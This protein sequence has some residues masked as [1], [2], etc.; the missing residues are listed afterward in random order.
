MHWARDMRSRILLFIAL[1]VLAFS[2]P[3]AARRH[4][5]IASGGS[6]TA[7]YPGDVSGANWTTAWPLFAWTS[8]KANAGASAVPVVNVI[9]ETTSTSCTIYL[10]GDGTPDVDLTTS[11]VGGVGHQCVGG[12]RTFCSST[13]SRCDVTNVTDATGGGQDCSIIIGVMYLALDQPSSGK[14]AID[15]GVSSGENNW[16]LAT[17]L[18]T[19][20][21]GLVSLAA[22]GERTSTLGKAIIMA[23]LDSGQALEMGSN[24]GQWTTTTAS[25]HAVEATANDNA[26]H[27]GAGI[28]NGTTNGGILNIDGNEFT[29]GPAVGY[30][31]I[32]TEHPFAFVNNNYALAGGT[33]TYGTFAGFADN[34]QW[35]QTQRQ[36][37]CHAL[38]TIEGQITPGT[39]C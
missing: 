29:G 34:V 21:T 36:Q 22:Y 19:P 3:S 13:N 28:V 32:G 16:C 15:T 10:K 18:F 33:H 6:P 27:A 20:A 35:T 26:W 9:G 39:Y 8:A 1:S 37:I 25:N 38:Y 23:E 24:T 12:A 11:G 14:I 30:P 2:L 17:N 7:T 4:G 5:G 31:F